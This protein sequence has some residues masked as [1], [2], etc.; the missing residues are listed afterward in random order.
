MFISIVV[1][2]GIDY[3]VYLLYRYQEENGRGSSP[4]EAASPDR[5][6]GRPGHVARSAH[7][8][9]RVLR[10]GAHRLPGHPGVRLRG[11]HRR[12]HGV[13][14][15]WSRSSPRCWVLLDGRRA[16]AAVP[17]AGNA[18]ERAIWLEPIIRVSEDDHRADR[19]ADGVHLLERHPRRLRLQHAQ[20]SRPRA[21]SPWRGKNGSS[22]RRGAPALPHSRPPRAST[23]SGR[24]REAFAALPT[25]AKVESVLMLVPD[26]QPEK[27]KLIQQFAPLLGARARRD[28]TRAGSGRPARAARDTAPA[29][30]AHHGGG[31]GTR[32]AARSE[33]RPRQA[34]RGPGQARPGRTP[35]Q[36]G[37]RA[38]ATPAADRA[39]LRRQAGR[40]S[41][42]A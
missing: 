18:V 4:V 10:A 32:P 38:R 41:R 20:A 1:G 3:G 31:G 2:I 6:A 25:V 11:G 33:H 9:R 27:V 23:S 40:A 8:D 13:S 28:S 21:W 15:R 14:C 17:A 12:P 34:G 30:A 29:P 36:A 16:A 19:S 39:R 37:A 35:R 42:R 22:P 26:R 7:G 24:S 5:R